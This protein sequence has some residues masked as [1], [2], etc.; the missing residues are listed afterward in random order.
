M[1]RVL[2]GSS[3]LNQSQVTFALQYGIV[4]YREMI[5]LDWQVLIVAF[6]ALSLQ[7]MTSINLMFGRSAVAKCNIWHETD[8]AC[9]DARRF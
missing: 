7:I 9:S 8:D 3:G 2:I 1:L 6:A 5:T 4:R